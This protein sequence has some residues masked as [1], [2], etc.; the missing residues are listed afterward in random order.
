MLMNSFIFSLQNGAMSISQRNG[1]ITLLPKKDKDPLCI[2][3][4]R[5]IT[6]LTVD[7]KILAKCLANRLKPCMNDVINSDQSGFL[8]G[9]NIGYN[10][11]LSLDIIEYTE[12][13]NIPAS[14]VLLDIEKAFDSVK[15]D[16]LLEILKRF[17]FG[18]KFIDWIKVIYSERKSYVI[19]NGY[20]TDRISM[21]RGIFQG[22]PISPYLFLFVI[23]I[24]ASVNSTER[25][26]Q[27]YF[28]KE[29]RSKYFSTSR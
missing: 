3:N 23:E 8:K 20:L 10:I 7:Y 2:K 1:I 17:N 28:C 21:Q 18:D 22:C 26:Y 16:F 4:Y 15:H 9:R 6:L 29:P 12:K 24:M 19:N 13:N 25:K 14:I 5:P 27:R 11:R